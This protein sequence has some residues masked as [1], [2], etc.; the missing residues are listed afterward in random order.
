MS[1]SLALKT[2]QRQ[3]SDSPYPGKLHLLEL[4][5]NVTLQSNTLS[6]TPLLL[7][8]KDRTTFLK[9]HVI[10]RACCVH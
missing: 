6:Y 7:L 1:I 3:F 10:L 8:L 4:I 9:I 2:S 5:S